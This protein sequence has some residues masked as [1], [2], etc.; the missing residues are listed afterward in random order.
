MTFLRDVVARGDGTCLRS[1]EESEPIR[2]YVSNNPQR[3]YTIV[4]RPM[5]S[6]RVKT[7]LTQRAAKSR[8]N[9]SLA[10]EVAVASLARN[11]P[12]YVGSWP[13]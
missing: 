12:L 13:S 9:L 2:K 4:V 1:G 5:K 7:V 8:L 10:E 6:V 3:Q 11:I